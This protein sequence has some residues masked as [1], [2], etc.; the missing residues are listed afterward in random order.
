MQQIIIDNKKFTKSF[1]NKFSYYYHIKLIKLT[2]NLKLT[3]NGIIGTKFYKK[4][5]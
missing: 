2:K 5:C 1:K 4:D 3:N